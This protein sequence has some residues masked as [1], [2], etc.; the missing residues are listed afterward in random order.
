MTKKQPWIVRVDLTE[1]ERWEIKRIAAARKITVEELG[2]RAFRRIL[3]SGKENNSALS[4]GENNGT[5]D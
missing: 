5:E 4:V 2:T 3:R 1:E